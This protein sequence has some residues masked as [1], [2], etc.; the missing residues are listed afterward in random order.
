MIL[1]KMDMPESCYLCPFLD[2]EYLVCNTPGKVSESLDMVGVT[3]RNH[4]HEDCP[5]IDFGKY[6]EESAKKMLEAYPFAKR[7]YF[8]SNK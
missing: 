6:V 3:Y 2:G 1:I 5:L 4:R 8:T 7:D